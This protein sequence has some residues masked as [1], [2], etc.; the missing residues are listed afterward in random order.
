MGGIGS[1]LCT[2]GQVTTQRH[3]LDVRRLQ[4]LGLLIPGKN[5]GG[6][7]LREGEEI[8]RLHMRTGIDEFTLTF[9]G[10]AKAACGSRRNATSSWNVP[11]AIWVELGYGFS[12][13]YVSV[14]PPSFIS[15]QAVS[16][17]VPATNLR[18][19]AKGRLTRIVRS[20]M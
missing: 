13:G 17:V 10:R 3:S 19:A 4:K 12:A 9:G 14:V 8:P 6:T 1:G 5:I 18:T 16:P 7:C 2:R 20:V 11:P 15:A